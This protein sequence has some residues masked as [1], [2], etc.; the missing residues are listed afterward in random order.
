MQLRP[1]FLAAAM[2]APLAPAAQATPPSS[3]YGLAFEETFSGSSVDTN[4]WS[5]RTDS[6]AYSTQV[7]ANATIAA[8]QLSLLMKQET[9]NGKPYTGAGILSKQLFG[10]GY[11][12]VQAQTTSNSGWH[13]SFWMMRAEGTLTSG[14]H[15]FL[16][17]DSF[18]INT[19]SPSAISSGLNT[20][21][22]T[23]HLTGPRCGN[24]SPSF[25]SS[26]AF[27]TYGADWSEAGID[28]YVD[29]VKYCHIDYSPA[30]NRQD[31]VNILLTA[32]A[33]STPVTVGGT[34]Q[35]FD[36]VRFY[37][38]DQYI[39]NGYYGYSEAGGGW[40]D[41]SLTGFGLMP[42]RYSCT[43]G[44]TATFAP[45]F[46]QAGNYHV[47]IWK[48]V[49]ANADTA[50]RIGVTTGG[51]TTYQMVNFTTGASGWV[52]LGTYSFASGTSGSVSNTVVNGCQRASAVKFVR[53]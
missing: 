6:K 12:E 13:N 42:A 25:D 2:V 46:N 52:D 11:Y 14:D 44:D 24:P 39:L 30:S 40:A 16:E 3:L 37:K 35:L 48:T 53:E 19:Q 15:R 22:G 41:S 38:R 21:N 23:T 26:A 4:K 47:Y 5:F 36:N 20:W 51:S 9:V 1:V 28:F 17:I 32:I 34:P 43:A 31:P 10:Y 45:G 33:Y 50:A 8:G 7:A 18:E 27:H 49:N 29:N